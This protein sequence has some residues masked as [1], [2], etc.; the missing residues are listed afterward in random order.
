MKHSNKQGLNMAGYDRGK[1]EDFRKWCDSYVKLATGLI[2]ANGAGLAACIKYLSSASPQYSVGTF[3]LLFV[4]GIILGGMFFVAMYFVKGDLTTAIVAQVRP[5][6]SIWGTVVEWSGCIG[7][8][9]SAAFFV[10]ALLLF[11]FRFRTL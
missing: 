6:R 3:I 5:G 10:A 8:W 7:V 9:G 11:A 2:L 1:L 4:L